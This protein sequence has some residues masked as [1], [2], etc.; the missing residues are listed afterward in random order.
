MNSFLLIRKFSSTALL[1]FLGLQIVKAQDDSGKENQ[2]N[3]TAQ[4]RPRFEYR[5]GNFQPLESGLKPSA[6]VTQRTRLSINYQYKNLLTVQVS[7]QTV[8]VWGQDGLTQGASNSNGMAFFEAWAKLKLGS[9]TSIQAGRQ[10]ISLDD[11]RFFGELDWA[12][13]GRSHDAVSFQYNNKKFDARLYAAY[14]QNLKELYSNNLSNVSGSLYTAKNAT[15]YKWMQTFW[16]KY[17]FNE[18]NTISFLVSNL[19]FQN[20]ATALDS[21]KASFSQTLGL[22]YFHSDNSWKYHASFYYQTGKISQT[23]ST[24]A[25]LLSIGLDKKITK[26]WNLGIG[27]DLL[28][29]N[30]ISSTTT[31]HSRAFVPYFG[32]N[33]K[34]Y[35]FMDY[36]YTGNGHKNTGLGDMF[37]KSGI[38]AN[39]KLNLGIAIHQFVSPITIK[40]GSKFLESNL[41][42]ELDLDFGFTINKF[43]KLSGGYSIYKT[44]PG[45]LYL[46][47]VE[48]SNDVQQWGWLALNINPK[49]FNFRY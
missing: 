16:S 23:V 37:L 11:E 19:G 17:Q 32:T 26:A 7:P 38:V 49:I 43:A 40:N 36:Y 6:L 48:Q 8:N 31:T 3:I 45:I 47:G 42:Q 34:F 12:Q 35:G 20:A 1:M 4:I 27:G 28:S 46:K 18:K 14:N 24:D 30:E 13:G 10:V 33:H 39:E 9:H 21:A 2:I 5:N 25:Y 29:G 22:N 15:P 44:T 41:G